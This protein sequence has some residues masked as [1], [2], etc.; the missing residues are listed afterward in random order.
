MSKKMKTYYKSVGM[1]CLFFGLFIG[2]MVAT[3]NNCNTEK[4]E[5]Q[6]VLLTETKETI[7]TNIT[8]TGK[9]NFATEMFWL[10]KGLR[11]ISY[12]YDGTRHFSIILYD[13]A[14]NYI[15]LIA[16]EI[17]EG[18][19]QNNFGN[20]GSTVITIKKSGYYLFDI[21]AEDMIWASVI[22]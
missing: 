11:R 19:G 17:G 12:A 18:Y 4:I 20:Y 13:S 3:S 14:G 2:A 10:D 9:G 15:D 6:E 7:I 22:K 1:V 21:S 5:M 8:L 16:N